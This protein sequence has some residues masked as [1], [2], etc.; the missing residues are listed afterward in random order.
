MMEFDGEFTSDHPRD[1]LWNYFT[2]PAILADCAPGCDEITMESP[3][4]LSATITVGVGSVKPTFDVD[5]TVTRADAPAILEMEVGG[6]ASR[7]SFEAVTEM[8]LVE[9]GDGTTATWEARTNVAGLIASMGQRALGSVAA[10]IVN[11]F[12]EDLEAKADEGVPAESKLEAKPEAEA[13][14]EN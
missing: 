14:I 6:D 8:C 3:G 13:S 1:D 5:M 2:D 7:N 9:D 12:F 4:E 10:R 11:N